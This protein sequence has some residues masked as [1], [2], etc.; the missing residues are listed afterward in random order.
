MSISYAVFCLTRRPP[1]SP[2]FPYTTLFR[3]GCPS[4][5]S[6]ADRLRLSAAGILAC[7]VAFT[8]AGL[9]FYKTTDGAAFS[10][11][12][13]AHLTVSGAHL[14]IQIVRSEEHTSELQS[15][16]NLVCR[17]LLDPPPTDISPLSLHD[18]LPIWMPQPRQSGR[19]AAPQRGRNPRLLGRLHCRRPRLLQDHRRRGILRRRGR[20]LDCLWRPPGDPDR[21]IGR[22]HV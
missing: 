19:S 9:A 18:A 4:P 14:A 20:A 21:Q 8:A 2:L 11:A 13:D 3:S 6:P 5:V 12:A 16:V 7:W 10:A 15:H 22:A 17:L 1:T